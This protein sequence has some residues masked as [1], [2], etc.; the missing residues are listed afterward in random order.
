MPLNLQRWTVAW[1]VLCVL[2]ALHL[3]EEAAS[4]DYRAYGQALDLL[5]VF[6]PQLPIPHFNFTVWLVDIA[7][8]I[9]V[10]FLLTGLVH[11]NYQ[12]MR[13]ASFALAIFT[14]ANAMLHILLSLASDRIL[15]GT[16][17]S[18]L[19]L[20]ASL[21]L[22]LTIP[23]AEHASAGAPAPATASGLR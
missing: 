21:F 6:F 1:F 7:G 5:R 13:P 11:R 8:A 14:T 3:A 9:I 23:R 22:L 10:L 18:P 19:L 16:L 2:L 17:T 20:V 12:I 4:G 15:A